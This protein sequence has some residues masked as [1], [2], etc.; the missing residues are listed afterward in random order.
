MNFL[1]TFAPV[2]VPCFVLIAKVLRKI[3]L[4]KIKIFISFEGVSNFGFGA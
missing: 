4:Q 1:A 3:L 2:A